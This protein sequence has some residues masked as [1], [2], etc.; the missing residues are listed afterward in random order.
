MEKNHNKFLIFSLVVAVLSIGIVSSFTAYADNDRVRSMVCN[1][2]EVMVGIM[3]YGGGDGISI[4]CQPEPLASSNMIPLHFEHKGILN[5]PSES[6]LTDLTEFA[7]WKIV[8]DPTVEENSII[9]SLEGLT[10]Y[11]KKSEGDGNVFLGFFISPDG[12]DWSSHK[13]VQTSSTTLKPQLARDAVDPIE[14]DTRYLAFGAFTNGD[15]TGEIKDVSGTVLLTLPVGYAIQ[16]EFPVDMPPVGDDH[17]AREYDD[18]DDDDDNDCD[19]GKKKKYKHH[20]DGKWNKWKYP[21]DKDGK[22]KYNDDNDGKW[23][24]W[25]HY[26]DD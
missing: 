3:G 9:G 23:N 5:V 17:C 1:A 4:V 12:E 10:A 7:V 16:Q 19:D 26:D 8:K 14:R 6:S 25:K 2:G 13:V 22:W 18:D 11:A 21:D 20:K 15:A 24:K